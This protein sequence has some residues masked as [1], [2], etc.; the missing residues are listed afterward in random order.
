MTSRVFGNVPVLYFFQK[1]TQMSLRQLLVVVKLLLELIFLS[2]IVLLEVASRN[3]KT[4]VLYCLFFKIYWYSLK[5]QQ[6]TCSQLLCIACFFRIYLSHI[7]QFK[8]HRTFQTTPLYFYNL[9]TCNIRNTQNLTFN[10]FML[11]FDKV[12]SLKFFKLKLRI[13]LIFRIRAPSSEKTCSN[14]IILEMVYFI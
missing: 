7:V 4:V 3:L 5:K 12:D 13:D 14:W 9:M 1:R 10:C 8:T 6:G 2:H 11:L